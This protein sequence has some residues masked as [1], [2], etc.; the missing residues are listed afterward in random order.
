MPSA[1]AACKACRR[2]VEMSRTCPKVT[3]AAETTYLLVA[4]GRPVSGA[5]SVAGKSQFHAQRSLRPQPQYALLDQVRRRKRNRLR[6]R[7]VELRVH[8]RRIGLESGRYIRTDPTRATGSRNK[9]GRHSPYLPRR[10]R[11]GSRQSATTRH[12]A[13]CLASA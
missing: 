11:V 4:T 10:S 6:V 3:S 13:G 2:D 9:I 8:L 7:L 5:T 12:E 1:S